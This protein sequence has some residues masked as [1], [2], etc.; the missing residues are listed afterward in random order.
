MIS[1]SGTLRAGSPHL[2]G[3]AIFWDASGAAVHGA[4]TSGLK[5]CGDEFLMNM[6][7]DPETC[8]GLIQWLTDVS[9]T[10]VAHFSDVGAMKVTAI[11]V[12]ECAACMVD[13]ENFSR[14]VVPATSRRWETDSA[15]CGFIR[16]A[17]AII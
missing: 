17:A 2:S 7:A 5:F 16:V 11:H 10:L 12:G 14:F 1:C 15:R 6:V 13:V 4:V 8:H 3:S 9:A